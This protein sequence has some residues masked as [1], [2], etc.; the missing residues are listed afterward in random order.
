MPLK[1]SQ[2]L[3]TPC[4]LKSGNGKEKTPGKHARSTWESWVSTIGKDSIMLGNYADKQS[5]ITALDFG[6]L[7]SLSWLYNFLFL[8]KYTSQ[9]KRATRDNLGLQLLINPKL[10]FGYHPCLQVLSWWVYFT[11]HTFSMRDV[12]Y[13][14]SS[15]VHRAEWVTILQRLHSC[16]VLC[17]TCRVG[18]NIATPAQLF[19]AVDCRFVKNE[20]EFNKINLSLKAWK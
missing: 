20:I 4:R 3:S 1:V 2:T 5:L 9:E 19:C 7:G 15:S 8:S 11:S 13:S 10:H 17:P 6:F 12:K 18:D 16:F 14:S